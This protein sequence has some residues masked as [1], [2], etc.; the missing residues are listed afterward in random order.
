MRGQTFRSTFSIHLEG[1][2]QLGSKEY[3]LRSMSVINKLL[4][5]KWMRIRFF[6][7]MAGRSVCRLFKLALRISRKYLTSFMSVQEHLSNQFPLSMSILVVPLNLPSILRSKTVKAQ[8][9]F[10][11]TPIWFISTLKLDLQ[12]RS[13]RENSKQSIEIL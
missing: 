7:L 3:Q 5:Q 2:F 8:S 9:G 10:Q 12:E 4:R 13:R 6:I 11:V 1:S